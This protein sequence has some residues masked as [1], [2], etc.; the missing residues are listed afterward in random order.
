MS[1]RETKLP[2]IMTVEKTAA[3]YEE[4]IHTCEYK[5]VP[6]TAIAAPSALTGWTGVWKIM[7]EDT[8]TDIRFMVFPM[9]NVSGDIS[10]NDM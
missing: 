4:N 5:K 10:S 9:L 6:N 8:I 1:L 2:F 3:L 7:M